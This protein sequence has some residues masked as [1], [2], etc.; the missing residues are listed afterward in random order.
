MKDT[1]GQ[2]LSHTANLLTVPPVPMKMSTPDLRASPP[3]TASAVQEP[4]ESVNLWLR[5]WVA[6]AVLVSCF[7]LVFQAGMFVERSSVQV[8]IAELR[9]HMLSHETAS[10]DVM[11]LRF[12]EMARRLDS[13]E[14]QIERLNGR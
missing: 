11:T 6:P 12:T 9:S 8:D 7:V 4:G 2:L 1:I 5:S 10:N 14:A 13:I 3:G